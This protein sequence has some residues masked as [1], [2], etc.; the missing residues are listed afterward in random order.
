MC[1]YIKNECTKPFLISNPILLNYSKKYILGTGDSSQRLFLQLCNLRVYVDGFI[2]D[3]LEGMTIYH[4]RIY[5]RA[6]LL[7][8]DSILLVTD[9]KMNLPF[10]VTICSEPLVIN[11]ILDCSNIYIFGAGNIGRKVLDI[12]HK[13]GVIVKGFI[14]TDEKKVNTDISGVKVYGSD[15]IKVLEKGTSVI[16]AG[17]YYQE[18]DSF[19]C[20]QNET[21]DRYYC[22]DT[23][24]YRDDVLLVDQDIVFD[25]IIFLD[26]IVDRKIYLCGKDYN[27]VDRYFE[28]FRLLDFENVCKAKWAEEFDDKDDEISCIEDALLEENYLIIFC[29]LISVED[30]EKLHNLGL[31]RGKDFCDIRCNIW[32]KYQ[33]IQILD[34]NLA[35]TRNMQGGNVPGIAVFGDNRVNDYKIAVLG[36]STSTSG[37]YLFRSWPEFFYEKYCGNGVTLFNGAVE[38][39]T[40]AQELIKLMRDIVC[41]K[42]DLVVVYDGNNDVARDDT[43]GIFQIPY[44]QTIM[45]YAGGKIGQ[46]VGKDGYQIFSGI[47]S[48]ESVI[49]TWLKN[50]QYMHAVCEINNIKFISF[51]QPMLFT[52]DKAVSAKEDIVRKKWEFFLSMYGRKAEYQMKEFRKCALDVH[53]TYD[54]I[55]D[56]SHIFD[57]KDV[58]MDHC[59]VYENGNEVIA[60]EI[61]KVIN[62]VVK[63]S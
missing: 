42:P 29:E 11:P 61:Y 48:S 14:D 60:D 22:H 32:E 40:S 33:G 51:M 49:D 6:E 26:D 19:I 59:H 63:I 30:M 27:L 39:Y 44:M 46:E 55:Y 7:A 15:M 16:E 1:A 45:E 2:D 9:R 57:D 36:G 38:G 43:Y 12:L 28:I 21:L 35:Y 3:E 52:K 56:L 5:S 10:V 13:R 37:F 4:K 50:I 18:I 20:G 23:D 53:R 24:M 47:H 8:N 62:E 17:K 25:G 41:L 54:Y 34:L 58:Y 31:E